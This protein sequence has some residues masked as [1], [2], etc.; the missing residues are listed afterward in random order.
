[1]MTTMIA[2][3]KNYKYGKAYSNSGNMS[4]FA[5]NFGGSKG[6]Y[7]FKNKATHGDSLHPITS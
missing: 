4:A 2:M 7:G 6:F 5:C 1:M 3:T